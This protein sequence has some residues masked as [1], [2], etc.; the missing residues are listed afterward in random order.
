MLFIL[1]FSTSVSSNFP[2]F[3]E[4][5]TK[6]QHTWGVKGTASPSAPTDKK[7]WNFISNCFLRILKIF[8]RMEPA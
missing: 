5:G 3:V 2:F 6:L 8:L 4:T 7:D 1:G